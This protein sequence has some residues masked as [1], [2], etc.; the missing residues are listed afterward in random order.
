MRRTR[1]RKGRKPTSGG[2]GGD[3]SRRDSNSPRPERKSRRKADD[4][5]QGGRGRRKKPDDPKTSRGR[6]KK[7]DDTPSAGRGS[8]KKPDGA[9]QQPGRG[10]GK[11]SD[12]T[13]QR[14]ASRPGR[15][16]ESGSH[17]TSRREQ[18]P[19]LATPEQLGTMLG[20]V[21]FQLTSVQLQLL[22]DYHAILLE[23][24]RQL[25]L[26]RILN[27]EDIVLK[28][29]VDCFLVAR[30]LPVLPE[31]LLDIG[32]G[33]GFPGIP[34][35]ILFP[36]SHIILGEG[37]RKRVN[38]LR[39]VREELKMT[40]LDIIGRNIDRDFEYPVNGT[41]TRAVATIRETLKR[42]SNCL[43]PGGQ[44]IFMKGPNVDQEIEDAG[45]KFPD[46][47]KLDKDI[48][49]SL[50]NSSYRRRLVIYRKLTREE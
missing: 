46:L 16:T 23:R 38:F 26:T 36:D 7:P 48:A 22:A 15:K 31:P 47:F 19:Q 33:A 5:Q 42:V 2:K 45:K 13:S 14:P 43:L 4:E 35:K 50:P 18:Q 27:L 30:Y 8:R 11:R 9:Q 12:S 21:G 24:N 10:R 25:N 39:D 40:K 17:R 1:D 20:K 41:I 32:S 37:V 3:R 6:R 49:Y 44:A 28:H 34:L 29:Y